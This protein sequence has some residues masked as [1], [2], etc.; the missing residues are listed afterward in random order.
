MRSKKGVWSAAWISGVE[1]EGDS[2]GRRDRARRQGVQ[3]KGDERMVSV[4][5]EHPA[6]DWMSVGRWDSM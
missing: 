2:M 4:M 6:W 3:S 1:E 5:K